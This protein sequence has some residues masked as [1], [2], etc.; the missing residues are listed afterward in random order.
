MEEAK[1]RGFLTASPAS[2]KAGRSPHSPSRIC[3][4]AV[5]IHLKERSQL[6]VS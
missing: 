3:A 4:S 6:S 1:M 5:S 2:Q